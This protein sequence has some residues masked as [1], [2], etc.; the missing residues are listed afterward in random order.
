MKK[1]LG[2]SISGALLA[3]LAWWNLSSP[4]SA[5]GAPRNRTDVTKTSRNEG[6]TRPG[7]SVLVTTASWTQVVPENKRRRSAVLQTLTTASTS[8]CLSSFTVTATACLTGKLHEGVVLEAGA[9]YT[10]FNE[11]IIY[12][13]ASGTTVGTT[14]YGNINYDAEDSATTD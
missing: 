4:R 11:A 1:I 6:D 14:V 9:S 7:F 10:D 3:S 12:G 8:V 13:R 5:W 2:L